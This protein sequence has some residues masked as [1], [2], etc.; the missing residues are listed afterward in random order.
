MV[1]PLSLALVYSAC[2]YLEYIGTSDSENDKSKQLP[3]VLTD[4]ILVF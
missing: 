2:Y 1:F 4:K 3:R